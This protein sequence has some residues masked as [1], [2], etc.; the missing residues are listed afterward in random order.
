MRF[1]FLVLL[2][3]FFTQLFV[4]PLSSIGLKY[5]PRELIVKTSAPVNTRDLSFAAP[6][7]DRLLAELSVKEIKPVTPSA[8][9]NYYIV[10][11]TE[12]FEW[13]NLR[14]RIDYA[15]L[16]SSAGIE[17]IQPNYINEM[18]IEPNDPLF[19]EQYLDLIRIPQA[20]QYETGSE[21]VIVAIIDSGL[22]FEHPEFVCES[23]IWI[24]HSEYPPNG[25]DSSGNGY[26]DDWRGWNFVDAPELSG[27]AIGNYVGQDNEPFD[28][29]GHGTHVSGIIVAKTNNNE[30]IAGVCWDIKMMILRAGFRTVTGAGYLQ[31][32]DAAA[33]IIYAADNG[34]HVINLSWG[35]N[36]FS[37][38]IADACQ[39]AYEKGS[40]IVASAGNN[41]RPE[42]M[43]P[44]RLNTTIAVGAVDNNLNPTSFTS[45][46]PDIDLMAPG[47]NVLSTYLDRD[48]RIYRRL[49]GTSMSAPYVSG[50]IALLLSSEPRLSFEEVK[51]RLLR[52]SKDMGVPGFDNRFGHGVLDAEKL[53]TISTGPYV[54]VT[55]PTNNQGFSQSFEIKGTVRTPDF[56]RYSVMFTDSKEPESFDWK[57]VITHN[58]SPH[59][60]YEEVED[61]VIT[62]FNIPHT[63]PDNNYLVRILIEDNRGNS[64]QSR[65]RVNVN[66]S[67]PKLI[68]ES[69]TVFERYSANF[70]YYYIQAKF[71]Q[72]VSLEIEL[73]K[74]TDIDN[75]VQDINIVHSNHSDSLHILKIPKL[76][77]GDY[78]FRISAVNNSSFRY[79]SDWY[80]NM[81]N[82]RPYAINSGNYQSQ[83][84]G[85]ALISI[86][87]SKDYNGNGLP[88]FIG[89]EYSPEQDKAEVGV[90]ELN[91]NREMELQHKFDDYFLPVDS[92]NTNNGGMEVLG[93][94]L[95]TAV[96]FEA[97][98]A[99]VY[100]NVTLWSK[101]AVNGGNFIDWNDN[102]VDD[103]FLVR[104]YEDQTIISFFERTG[105][106]FTE[107]NTLFNKTESDNRNQFVPKVIAS[108]FNNNGY[109]NVIAADTDGDIMIFEIYNEKQDSLIFQHRLPVSDAYHISSGDFT[110]DGY[111]E[112]CVGGHSFNHADP[113]KTFWYFEFFGYDRDGINGTSNRFRSLGYVS[114]D[115]YEPVNAIKAV[116]FNEDGK[117]S[118]VVALTPYLY[119]V[120]YENKEFKPDWQGSSHDTYQ[121]IPIAENVNTPSGVIVNDYYQGK[122]HSHFV[123]LSKHSGPPTPAGLTVDPKDEESVLL[124]WNSNDADYYYIYRKDCD[125]NNKY[126]KSY[127]AVFIDSVTTNY[128]LD[129][130]LE[131]GKDYCYALQ[132]YNRLY[133]PPKS[134]L[135]PWVRATPNP[136]PTIISAT[137]ISPY[138]LHILFDM[139]LANDA[140]NVGFYRVNN[141]KGIPLSVNHT[142][143]HK[144]LLLRFRDP[145]TDPQE[146]YF[147][148]I[149]GIKGRTG[150]PVPN[151]RF[152]FEFESDFTKP[153]IVSYTVHKERQLRVNFNKSINPDTALDVNNY[154]LKTPL[155]DKLNRIYEV[156][157]A[158]SALVFIFK[159]DLKVTNQPYSL[160]MGKIEDLAGNTLPNDNNILHFQVASIDNLDYVQ[161]VPN[162][163]IKG[164]PGH[165]NMQLIGL[166]LNTKGSFY[167]YSLAGELIYQEDIDSLTPSRSIWEWNVTN[168]SGRRIS[169]GA[170]FY[171]VIMDDKIKKG[172]F[173]I[174][175]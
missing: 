127:G 128:Y 57:D 43:Y 27:I 125:Y 7:L 45:Y 159:N 170:Y 131:A 29:T 53:L 140:I 165:A 120:N 136:V 107:R 157:V 106:T 154:D 64:Y 28:E 104:S 155:V 81:L 14:R 10:R 54:E 123:S 141:N 91:Y 9:N 4:Q 44:A 42:V 62:K 80:E 17:H 32:D 75:E 109:M 3:L 99:E 143:N 50:A 114:F 138:E 139:Q 83:I 66:Q 149:N 30:G 41:P 39:Y 146:P 122:L 82:V 111:K 151:Q 40:I 36:R 96:I 90:F 89:L 145:F 35:S 84:V 175:N 46:G 121:I 132:A 21:Q 56:F 63:L 19:S 167:L 79:T 113:G 26:I 52:S 60:Y 94:M 61:D 93:L 33:A 31:D 172:K 12:D 148:E 18:L 144:G 25:E 124:T 68:A 74:N 76:A 34:A 133:L 126:Y 95:D 115:H 161:I 168:K 173:I 78:S 55:Y 163:M 51:S 118:L 71:D 6:E 24:N 171:V 86:G 8:T 102:G 15:R 49:S 92:G 150:V 47:Q 166:P 5:T 69:L 23:N 37:R 2:S 135:S 130:G 156:N 108:D 129:S 110:G 67:K 164:N 137:H 152:F 58:N 174:V 169:S 119:I 73:K 38:I 160:K 116:D 77:H 59:Y 103:L 65:F 85:P 16:G 117:Y 22:W 48:D 100:P 112:F 162:P 97:Y 13:N 87:K 1:I 70:L 98:G 147:V 153:L 105:N 142:H 11:V 72:S 20:W 158:D 101:D 134:E 88:E